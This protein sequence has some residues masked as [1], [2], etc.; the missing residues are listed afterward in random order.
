MDIAEIIDAG[1]G[2]VKGGLGCWWLF[3]SFAEPEVDIIDPDFA[4]DA[5]DWVVDPEPEFEFFDGCAID[6]VGDFDEPAHFFPFIRFGVAPSAVEVGG[7]E[8]GAI[9]GGIEKVH[10]NDGRGP[11]GGCVGFGVGGEGV[12]LPRYDGDIRSEWCIDPIV[13]VHEFHR[14]GA[15]RS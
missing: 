6:L 2:A 15:D 12:C 10:P 9:G 4:V 11:A 8:E 13:G 1:L 14:S 7:C 3:E 5:V